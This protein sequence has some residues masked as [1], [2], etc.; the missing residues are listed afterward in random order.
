MAAKVNA[1]E[2]SI[3]SMDDATLKDQTVKLKNLYSAGS[4]L[5]ELLPEAYA[6]VREAAKRS[7]GQR[8]YDVQIMGGIALHR[9]NIAEMKTGEGKALVATLAS[10]LNALSGKGVHVVT[11]NDYLAKRDSLW[12]G[13]IHEFL[14]LTVGVILSN[15][16]PLERKKAYICD[17]TYGT[18]NEFG[19]DYLRDNMVGNKEELTQRGHNFAVI[20]EVDSILIDEARTP[21]IISGPADKATEWYEKF[22]MIVKTLV[23]ER[24]YEVDEKKKTV[25][26][27]EP[28]IDRVEESLG[29]ENLYENSNTHLITYLNSALKAKELFKK[30]VD[31]II[32]SNELL[33][34]DEHT[35]RVLSGRRYSEG[36]HQALEAKEKVTIQDENQTLATITLQN[37]FRLYGKLSGMTGTALTEAS[38]FMQI[39]SLGVVQIPTNKPSLRVDY[40]DLVFLTH[41]AK[42][43]AIIEDII[44]RHK[45]GQP[46]LV[47]TV[48][49]ESSE[50]I[51]HALKLKGIKH[52]VL[53]AKQHE[54][55]AHI[56][57]L[58][59]QINSVT[60]ATNMAGRGTDIILGGNPDYLATLNLPSNYTQ[61]D[62][63]TQKKL[64][65]KELL[66]QKDNLV[67]IA[68]EINTLGGLY[69]L[70]TARHDSRRIDN[71]LRGRAGRQGDPGE[72]RFYL[73]LEDDLMRR[74]NSGLM[75]KLLSAQSLDQAQAIE[76]KM[77]TRSIQSAQTQMESLNFE[78]RK[79]ILKYDNV[80][81]KQ[82]EVIY[83]SRRLL[84]EKSDVTK[85]IDQ[86]I[87]ESINKIVDNFFAKG[88]PEDWQFDKF[89]IALKEIYP[90]Q[91]TSIEL[92][93][94]INSNGKDLNE[95]IKDMLVKETIAVV[96]SHKEKIGN[97]L[98]QQV[99]RQIMLNAIDTAWRSHLYE[100]DYLQEGIGLRAMAQRDPLVEYQNEG[101]HLFTSMLEQIKENVVHMFLN[102]NINI[103]EDIK[104]IESES[105][106]LKKQVKNSFINSSNESKNPNLPSRNSLCSCGSGKK[107]K[108]CHGEN[109]LK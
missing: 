84:L 104:A 9:G 55:E 20:D 105:E 6:T 14:G 78:Q 77:I 70:G 82:R 28:G 89:I 35:G 93:E 42:L 44:T 34:V 63:A 17:I 31:Y 94:L 68:K 25:G 85:Q 12:M 47:G 40:P 2:N 24:D 103:Q 11:V 71:Q 52:E 66:L 37:Y 73:S 76:S 5:E 97:E 86:Y 81:S 74:F 22:A 50:E 32:Q 109:K 102:L 43:N 10:Y 51:S 26:I 4:T 56:V 45:L 100:M 46:I 61:L 38:E 39:Y 23:R 65:E 90:T 59:G 29:I 33:I 60:V 106:K 21:L 41:Q 49:V 83:D 92:R 19:F 107:F 62:E 18:N 79:D 3:S 30:D 7:I 95:M 64:H 57:A 15:M 53:N 80:L 87:Q 96:E 67:E 16:D 1:L 54:R 75:S 27:L 69:I 99:E 88:Y 58:A 48:S 13:R 72:T 91:I 108:R 98:L 101:F 8:H 36:L